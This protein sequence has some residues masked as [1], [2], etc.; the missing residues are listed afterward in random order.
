[1]NQSLS[2]R[3]K[4]RVYRVEDFLRSNTERLTD[5]SSFDFL[6]KWMDSDRADTIT[7]VITHV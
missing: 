3:M 5:I 1:M 2:D 6:D 7:F 4:A